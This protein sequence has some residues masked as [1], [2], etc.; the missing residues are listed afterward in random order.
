MIMHYDVMNALCMY[1]CYKKRVKQL[2]KD[3][4]SKTL[5]DRPIGI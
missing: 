4:S 1:C 3:S 5:I 2:E